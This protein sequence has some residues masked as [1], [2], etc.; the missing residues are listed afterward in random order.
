MRILP[1]S[2]T[3]S[4]ARYRVAEWQLARSRLRTGALVV[5]VAAVLLA[6]YYSGPQGH[7]QWAMVAA[8][9]AFF[10]YDSA[11]CWRG[12][13]RSFA[14]QQGQWWLVIDGER[15]AAQL[16]GFHFT[17][18]RLGVIRF[19]TLAG[20]RHVVTILPDSL[21]GEACRKLV[22]ALG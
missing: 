16:Q 15:V 8:L 6:L 13:V 22:L 19:R 20:A 17:G 5:I 11:R 12:C 14:L 21:S 9:G 1:T 2:S 10:V 18:R 7:L 4:W 3:R